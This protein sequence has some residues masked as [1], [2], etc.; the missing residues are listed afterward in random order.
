MITKMA[1]QN[2]NRTKGIEL[3]CVLVKFIKEK[4]KKR[5]LQVNFKRRG[6]CYIP[7]PFRVNNSDDN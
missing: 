3:H 7:H 2:S 5:C 6:E 4:A 1:W